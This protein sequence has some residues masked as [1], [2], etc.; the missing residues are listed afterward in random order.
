MTAN[1]CG[2]LNPAPSV[3]EYIELY[4]YGVTPV[5]VGGWWFATNNGG[6]NSHPNKL[7]SWESRNSYNPISGQVITNSTVIEPLHYAVILTPIYYQGDERYPFPSG[8]TILTIE[9]GNF[10]GNDATGLLGNTPPLTVIVLYEG[11]SELIRQRIST[12]GSPSPGATVDTIQAISTI[13]PYRLGVCY[14]VR[15]VDLQ[16]QMR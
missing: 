4:N 11:T 7:V 12:Y 1:P 2:S 5:D 15:R 3:N 13:F 16:L 9:A 10:L 8:T 6:E 14:S